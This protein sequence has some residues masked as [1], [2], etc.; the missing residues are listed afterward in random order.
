MIR[1]FIVTIFSVIILDAAPFALKRID[2]Q[3]NVVRLEHLRD[4]VQLIVTGQHAD[5]HV[6][7]VTHLSKYTIA[8]PAIATIERALVKSRAQG[9][10]DVIVEYGEHQ[11]KITVTTEAKARVIS[12]GHDTLPLLSKLGCSSG[13]CHGSPHGKGGFRLSLRAFDPVLDEYTLT[14]EEFGRSTNPLNPVSSLLLAKPSME[15]AHEGG[16]RFRRGDEQYNLLRD[17]IAEGCQVNNNEPSCV[18]LE[19]APVSGRVLKHPAWTQ[20]LRVVAHFEDGTQRDITRLAVFKISDDKVAD[21]DLNGRVNG[22]RRGEAAVLVR[23]LEHIE[24]VLLTF[25]R[26]VEGFEWPNLPQHNYVDQHVDTKLRQLQFPPSNICD[27]TTFVRRVYLDVIGILPT[28]SETQSFLVNKKAD[29]RERLIDALLD[30]PE[31]AK[32]WALKWGDLLRLSV[33]QIGESSVYKYHRWI[34]SAFAANMPYDRFAT[35]LLTARGSTLVNPPANFYRTAA[36][37]DDS[38]ETSAQ[39]FLGTRIQCAKCHNHPFERWTQ[40]NYYGMASFF[41]RI[42]RRRTGKGD[43]TWVY[44]AKSGEVTHPLNGKTMKPWAPIAGKM[45][46]VPGSD[47]RLE[48]TRWLTRPNN[49]FFARVEVNRLWAQ[50][51]GRGIVEPFDDFRDTNPPSNAPLLDALTSDFVKSGYDRRHALRVIL[52]SRTYQANSRAVPLN[53]DDRKYFSH[54]SARMLSAE[55]L[56]DAIGQVTGVPERLK[57]LPPDMKCTQVPAPELANVDFLKIFGQPERQSVCECD[58]SDEGSLERAL[59]L[60]NGRLLDRR[61]K[62]GSNRFRRMLA[63]GKT[64]DEITRDLY[65]SALSREPTIAELKIVR[66][67]ISARKDRI[68]ALENI[69]WALLNKTEFLFQ[70]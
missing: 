40:D 54:Y 10:T 8:N 36:N 53:R 23:Y 17:W 68:L 35:E 3:P 60:Y 28:L 6:T 34:E 63:A 7:D 12:F 25:V 48:F 58:R 1:C 50:V 67:H 69:I 11:A 5:G 64:D 44:D 20:Q 47:R 18:K 31:H 27:D 52:N 2:V 46:L 43:E 66:A 29:K 41:N 39:I 49:P 14:R 26:D 19:V 4:E 70:H 24:S 9:A 32:F 57:G 16:R 59:Q 21:V 65:L 33:K 42:Q 51:M 22:I 61:L 55:Q 62:D 38:V 45:D 15:V 13:S 56:L 30:R 37:R